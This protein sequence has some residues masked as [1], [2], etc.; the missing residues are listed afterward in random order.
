MLSL[1]NI[2]FIKKPSKQIFHDRWKFTVYLPKWD[3]DKLFEVIAD[4]Y[5][6]DTSTINM[7]YI[8]SH[9][10]GSFEVTDYRFSEWLKGFIER[11]RGWR[12]TVTNIPKSY[13]DED[14]RNNFGCWRFDVSLSTPDFTELFN[15][16]RHTDV[17]NGIEIVHEFSN[18]DGSS[19][20]T[21]L[22][23]IVRSSELYSSL[24]DEFKQ[25]GYHFHVQHVIPD[26]KRILSSL[27]GLPTDASDKEHAEA[28][29]KEDNKMSK[30]KMQPPTY[31]SNFRKFTKV[32]RSGPVTVAWIEGKKV[33]VR[34]TKKDKDDLE[35]AMLM[36]YAKSQFGSEAAFHRWFRDQMKLFEEADKNAKN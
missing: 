2:D 18:F 14:A 32:I 4:D 33:M 25:K 3:A 24:C 6:C 36:L 34:K 17:K 12:C 21:D 26:Y 5:R 28:I 22:S 31:Y 9:I 8:L 10:E 15:R 35:K 7:E 29:V 30:V 20:L 23:F 13:T 11:Q 16:W 1:D 27:S 19:S